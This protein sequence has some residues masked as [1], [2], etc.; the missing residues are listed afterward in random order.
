MLRGNPDKGKVKDESFGGVFFS[1]SLFSFIYFYFCILLHEFITL[2]VVQSSSPPNFIASFLK[3]FG[4]FWRLLSNLIRF[5][6]VTLGTISGSKEST[7][8]S[9]R[10]SV[11]TYVGKESEKE[12]VPA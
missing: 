10:Y 12:W 2:I 8:D 7:G 1:V 3:S 11:M 5:K 6:D 4:D 9:A